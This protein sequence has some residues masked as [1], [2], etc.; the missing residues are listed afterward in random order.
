MII[1]VACKVNNRI[2]HDLLRTFEVVRA[3]QH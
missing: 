2:T 1:D 3:L